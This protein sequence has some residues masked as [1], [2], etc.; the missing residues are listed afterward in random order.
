MPTKPA[1]PKSSQPYNSTCPSKL[2]G[3]AILLEKPDQTKLVPL[4]AEFE[5]RTLG[6]RIFGADFS[7][8]EAAKEI[9][10]MGEDDEKMGNKFQL[11]QRRLQLDLIPISTSKS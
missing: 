10:L 4:L 6:K 5:F 7:A 3:E 11:A 2:T 9:V 8:Q 1:C